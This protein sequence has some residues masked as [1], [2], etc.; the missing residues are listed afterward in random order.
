MKNCLFI[1]IFIIF[2]VGLVSAEERHYINIGGNPV[3]K[4]MCQK[5]NLQ[6]HKITDD[7]YSVI[8]DKDRNLIIGWL[9]AGEEIGRLPDGKEVVCRCGN[10]VKFLETPIV[11]EKEIEKPES[12]LEK[13]KKII[14]IINRTVEPNIMSVVERP[15]PVIDYGWSWGYSPH[16][17]SGSRTTRWITSDT[18]HHHRKPVR[19]SYKKPRPQ[20]QPRSQPQHPS[21]RRIPHPSSPLVP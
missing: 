12:E 16:Y 7:K 14:I 3:E 11:A 15:S 8:T 18:H 4:E 1:G 6:T 20:P 5:R 21:P 19:H 13:K 17:Y 9:K 10:Q 2:F